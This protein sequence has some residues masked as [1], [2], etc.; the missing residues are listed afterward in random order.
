MTNKKKILLAEASRT[1]SK[2]IAG[3][4]KESGYAV[5]I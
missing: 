3:A 5:E 4:L 2:I 1:L